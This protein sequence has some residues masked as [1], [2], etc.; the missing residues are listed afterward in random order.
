[1][2]REINLSDLPDELSDKIIKKANE[3]IEKYE[4]NANPVHI[5][6]KS[7]II[8]LN[9]ESDK[10]IRLYNELE[11]TVKSSLSDILEKNDKYTKNEIDK[12]KD[13]IEFKQTG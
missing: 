1:M 10:I 3:T 8:T 5:M 11:Q 4:F 7:K 2:M 6:P 9:G 12:Y 13:C